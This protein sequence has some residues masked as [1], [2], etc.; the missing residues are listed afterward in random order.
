[1]SAKRNANA[2]DPRQ[3]RAMERLEKRRE[4]R[5]RDTLRAVMATPSGRLFIWMTI[6]RAGV[7]E[8]PFDAH[9]GIQSFKIGRGDM[10]REIMGEVLRWAPDEYLVMEAEA[11][12]VDRLEQQQAEAAQTAPAEN[13][14][15]G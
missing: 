10:G 1:M 15:E 6:R 8:S 7:F 13:E 5:W 2:A 14:G 4:D 9:G 3:V 12:K 11:R